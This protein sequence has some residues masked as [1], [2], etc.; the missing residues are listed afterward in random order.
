MQALKLLIYKIFFDILIA[1]NI[2]L[3]LIY[4]HLNFG[5]INNID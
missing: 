1:I 3:I 2:L 4:V 5:K